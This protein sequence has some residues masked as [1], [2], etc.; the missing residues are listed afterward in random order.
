MPIVSTGHITITD[1]MDGLNARLSSESH[2]LPSDNFG[3]VSSFVGCASTMSVYQ[4]NVDDTLNWTFSAIP[5]NLS[6]NLAGSTYT[7]TAI[8]ADVGYVD[9]TASKVGQP[10]ITTRF[11]VAKAREGAAGPSIS[12]ISSGQG[13]TYEDGIAT[14]VSQTIAVTVVRQ[15]VNDP[16]IFV[17]SNGVIP[18][19]DDGKLVMLNY[20]FGAPGVGRGDTM[21]FDLADF[22]SAK[23]V[24]ITALCGEM[25]ASITLMRLEKSTA[26]A[27]ATRNVFKGDWLTATDYVIGDIVLH[28]GSSWSCILAHTSSGSILPP[29]MPTSFNTYWTLYGAIG[30][31]PYVAMLSNEVH[32]VPTLNDGTGGNFAGC[33][34]TM[35]V[36]YGVVDDST[37]GW[38]YSVV[39]SAGVTCSEATTSRTQTVTALTGVD[40]GT[41]TFTASKGGVSLV[42]V[43]SIAKSKAGVLGV[44]GATQERVELYW[45]GGS[46]PTK[47]TSCLYTISTTTLGLQTGGTA[48]WSLTRPATPAHPSAVYMT[49][50]IASTSTPATQLSLTSFTDP[51]VVAQN[52]ASGS[53]GNVVYAATVYRQIGSATAPTGGNFNAATAVLTAPTNWSITQPPTSTTPTYASEFVFNVVAGSTTNAGGTWSTP[54]IDAVAGA[55]GAQGP[56]VV[57]T[58]NIQAAFTATDG[59][60][61][62][63]NLVPTPQINPDITFTAVV[64]GITS[65]SYVWSFSGFPVGSVPTNSGAATQ[66]VTALQ[67]GVAKSALVTCTVSGAY[68]DKVTIVRLEKSTAAAGATANVMT[69]GLLSARPTGANGDTY[70]AT[71]TTLFY[72][73]I[74]GSWVTTANN[75]TQT[76]QLINNSSWD[77]T[78]ATLT[79]GTTITGG[80]ITLSS[81]GSIKS[82]GKTWD[83]TTE[84][85]YL[86]YAGV[87]GKY[88]LDIVGSGQFRVRSATSGARMEIL[89]NVIKVYDSAGVLRVQIGDLSA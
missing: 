43:F 61:D 49:T 72:Q 6:G 67:F 31:S 83:N 62:A 19:T 4:G 29:T 40:T 17:P 38:T 11:S 71:D 30:L 73:K 1:L 44:N 28:N 10:N 81:G 82:S 34:T 9:I 14:P 63:K 51:V 16:V 2:L 76:S 75:I 33:S 26:V 69:S 55:A 80:G 84:G 60:L 87:A 48:G 3:V 88:G 35:S 47:P 25:T 78:N 21:Y 54:Y 74:A 13:F 77:S 20:I 68:V 41:V 8:S 12:L 59:T 56:S 36:F 37:N 52:G 46:V 32:V 45:A 5:T 53:S 70:F 50:A 18:K 66:V 89:D 58:P 39:K 57:V 27:G 23:Q 64:S 79:T 65:P 15:G 22:G 7:V 86:G 85:F 24:V 42:S